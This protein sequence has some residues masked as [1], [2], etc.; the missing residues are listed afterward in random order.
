M[1]QILCPPNRTGRNACGH[2]AADPLNGEVQPFTFTFNL[3]NDALNDLPNHLLAVSYSGGSPGHD[4]LYTSGSVSRLDSEPLPRITKLDF[5][6]LSDLVPSK[7]PV[8]LVSHSQQGSHDQ[9]C[10]TGC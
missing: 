10:P 6:W 5:S 1:T 4:L 2:P 8:S 9:V 7:C 3:H